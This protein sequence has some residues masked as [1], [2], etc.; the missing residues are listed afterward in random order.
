MEAGPRRARERPV[1]DGMTYVS[2]PL[3][4]SGDPPSGSLVEPHRLMA[5]S[6][7]DA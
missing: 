4:S 1:Q 3:N 2:I 6:R 7:K 5:E